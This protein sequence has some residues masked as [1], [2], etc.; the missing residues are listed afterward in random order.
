MRTSHLLRLLVALAGIVVVLAGSRLTDAYYSS[1]A[2]AR[3]GVFATGADQN[4]VVGSCSATGTAVEMNF[5]WSPVPAAATY[6]VWVEATP[7]AT[8]GSQL[9]AT[10]SQIQPLPDTYK[11][12][13]YKANKLA[14]G[15]SGWAYVLAY[16]AAGKLLSRSNAIEYR[17]NANTPG[18]CLR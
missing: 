4:V 13:N 9:G 11:S 5:Y 18:T 3:T 2:V 12:A 1:S 8:G 6:Q 15:V 10:I 16:D 7:E 14:D 17:K